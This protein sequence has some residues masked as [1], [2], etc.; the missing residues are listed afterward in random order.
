MSESVSVLI[1]TD[2]TNTPDKGAPSSHEGGTVSLMFFMD[3]DAFEPG[4]AGVQLND[5]LG[6][7]A[8]RVTDELADKWDGWYGPVN[9]IEP[10]NGLPT[11]LRDAIIMFVSRSHIASSLS[12]VLGGIYEGLPEGTAAKEAFKAATTLAVKS[13]LDQIGPEGVMVTFPSSGPVK[14]IV[15]MS[16]EGVVVTDTGG[17]PFPNIDAAVAAAEDPTSGCTG[18]EFMELNTFIGDITLQISS[19]MAIM[20]D[21]ES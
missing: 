2:R 10:L 6:E 7:I 14:G 1:N 15:L 11:Q 3:D 4:T 17:K 13:T 5:V 19:G 21:P 12:V 8:F 9:E 18:Y 20:E 16:P